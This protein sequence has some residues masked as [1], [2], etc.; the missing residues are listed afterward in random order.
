MSVF[1]VAAQ[2]SHGGINRHAISRSRD[3]VR[4]RSATSTEPV[5]DFDAQIICTMTSRCGHRVDV[6]RFKT[7]SWSDD[8]PLLENSIFS[9]CIL[10]G[11]MP[12]AAVHE[13]LPW[14]NKNDFG[15]ANERQSRQFACRNAQL[16]LSAPLGRPQLLMVA[17]VVQTSKFPS[18]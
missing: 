2:Q 6:L 10:A 1:C 12:V 13:Q 17:M 18:W 9:A 4:K 8:L 7:R 5:S 11:E 16:M 15:N 14:L 3:W